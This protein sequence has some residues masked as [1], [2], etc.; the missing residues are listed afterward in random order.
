MGQISKILERRSPV[1]HIAS[2]QQLVSDAV[3]VMATQQIGAVPIVDQ[4]GRLVGIFSERDLVRRVSAMG[5]AP[6]KTE[7]A[8]VMTPNPVTAEPSEER[9]VA[10]AKMQ[11]V[12][13]RHLP[14]VAAGAIIDM[15]SMRDLLFVE[16]EERQAEVDSLRRY[17]GGSY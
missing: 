5:R 9:L 11:K 4:A 14:V 3:S 10:I 17:I 7:L 6:E 12:G 2:P 13:C 8:E 16:L 1:V 15:L